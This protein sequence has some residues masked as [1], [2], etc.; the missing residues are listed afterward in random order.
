MEISPGINSKQFVP[1]SYNDVKSNKS[2]AFVENETNSRNNSSLRSKLGLIP[3][4][5]TY[6]PPI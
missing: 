2:P 6:R 1:V 3:T 4:K 5:N